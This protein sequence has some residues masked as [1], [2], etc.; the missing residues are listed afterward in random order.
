MKTKPMTDDEAW[1][2]IMHIARQHHFIVQAYGGTA[3]LAIAEEQE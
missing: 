2:H 3:T 1:D